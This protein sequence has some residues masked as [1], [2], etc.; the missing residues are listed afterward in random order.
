[1]CD[2]KYGQK[3]LCRTFQVRR[4]VDSSGRIIGLL[5]SAAAL[6][7]TRLARSCAALDAVLRN[8][9]HFGEM[10]ASLGKELTSSIGVV[11]LALANR[12]H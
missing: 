9:T 8:G 7:A 4:V 12:P 3:C 10:V 1:M 5:G 11:Q 2:V 6:G